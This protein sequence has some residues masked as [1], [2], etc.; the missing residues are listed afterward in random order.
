M[1]ENKRVMMVRP[2]KRFTRMG[3]AQPLGFLHLISILRRDFPQM[4]EIELVEQALWDLAAEDVREKMHQFKPDLVLF[5]CMSVEANEMRELAA[6]SKKDFPEVPVWIGGPH[7]TIFYDW[8]L[9]NG[10]VDAACIGE[11]EQTF[12]EM[13]QAWLQGNPLSKV[14]GLA[15][16]QD[17]EIITTGERQPIMDLD[18][19]PLPAWDMVDFDKYS[20][21][22][23]MTG[24]AHS[25]PWAIFFTS[26]ACPYQCVYCH[27]IFGKRVRKRSIE[28]VMQE[29]ELLVNKCGVKEIHIVDDIFNLDL[30]RAKA[31][32]DEIV[33]RGLEIKIAFPNGLRGDRMDRELIQKLKAA[34][35]YTI[36]YAV[37]TASPRL[38]KRI[39]KNVDLEKMREVIEWTDKEGLIAQAFFM[40]GF[41][42]ETVAEMRKTIDY[43]LDS[44]LLKPWFFAVVVYPRTGLYDMAKEEYPDFDFS[45]YDFFNLRYWA[46][47]PF[48]TRVTGVD[49]Y[50]IQRDA[51]R[52]FLFR[53]SV[54]LRIIW[55][56]P[57]NKLFFRGIYW[58]VRSVITSLTKLEP[59]F[60]P[61]RLWLGRWFEIFRE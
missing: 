14:P 27:N 53:P 38:Q 47:V 54:I 46:E 52:A 32:C 8:E 43:A 34:G 31:I 40:L 19:L 15:I 1:P 55:R 12:K 11:G 7:P 21:Q 48:Y 45:G 22:I 58:G 51:Y 37:E 61:A 13:V 23:T 29:L 60:R 17:G 44:R 25:P 28:H 16:K 57:K 2:G 30:P 41:P 35:C 33:R 59:L 20:R 42:G 3:F 56:F 39:R 24:F 10:N 18:S 36:T 50:K 26:R 4:F 6:I 9:E 5:S 49:L